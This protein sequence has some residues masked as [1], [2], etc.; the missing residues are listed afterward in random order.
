MRA[1][2]TLP[3]LYNFRRCP[4][5]IRAR[6]AI[7]VSG[8]VCELREVSLANKPADM[9]LASPKA[10]VPVMV[11]TD[12][13]VLEQSLDIMAYALAFNDPNNWG[14]PVG[15]EAMGLIELVDTRFKDH[16]DRYKYPDRHDGDGSKDKELGLAVLA[17]FDTLL[18]KDAYLVGPKFSLIDAAILPFVRQFAAVD[19]DWFASQPIPKVHAWLSEFLDGDLFKAAMTSQPVWKPGDPATLFPAGSAR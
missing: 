10:T 7:V 14:G 11:L 2:M 8:L 19:L 6:L 18:T 16:L 17:D 3:I 4:Y 12:A 1:R 13:T 15:A 5:A 9:I